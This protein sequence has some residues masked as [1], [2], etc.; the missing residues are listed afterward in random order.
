MSPDAHLSKWPHLAKP[1][2]PTETRR[3]E[4]RRSSLEVATPTETKRAHLSQRPHLHR[5]RKRLCLSARFCHFGRCCLTSCRWNLAPSLPVKFWITDSIRGG[6]FSGPVWI[7]SGSILEVQHY[8]NR[9]PTIGRVSHGARTCARSA[10]Q[11]ACGVVSR[12][13]DV[14]A[15]RR[16]TSIM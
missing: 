16:C 7:H 13:G 5:L 15:C 9:A 1:N 3:N 10:R 12:H 4:T 6:Q 8:Q 2:V 14:V 11:A